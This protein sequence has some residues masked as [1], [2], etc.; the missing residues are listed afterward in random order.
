MAL[1]LRLFDATCL[2]VLRYGSKAWSLTAA[3]QDSVNCFASMATGSCWGFAGQT[4]YINSVMLDVVGRVPLSITVTSRQL[5]HLG[6][7]LRKER[8]SIPYMYARYN[9]SHG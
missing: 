7:N 4:T 9:P 6:H 2:P 3:M 8:I 5:T 1:K